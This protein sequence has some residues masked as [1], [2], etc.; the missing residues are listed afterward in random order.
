MTGDPR[1]RFDTFMGVFTPTLLTILG[2]I[3]YVRL[4]WVVGNA[5]LLGAWLILLLALGI[6]AATALSLSSIATNTRIGDGGPY[7]IIARSLGF[8][9]GG[10]VG[11]P[12]F[13]TRPLGIAMYIFGFREGWQWVFPEHPALLIDLTT[14]GVLFG[15]AWLSADL[16]FRVQ[17]AI[18]AVILAS[19]VSIVAS[20]VT[21][22]PLHDIPWWGTYPGSPETGLSGTNFWG[23]FA[24]FFPA[25][26]GILAGANM[27]GELKDPRRAIPLGTLAAIVVASFIY[28]A[29]SVWALQAGTV[30]ELVSNYTLFMDKARWGNLVLAGLLGATAS[31]ALAGLVGGPRILL[32]I[33]RHRLLPAGEW[34]GTVSKDGEPRN[35]M[36]VTGVLTLACLMLRDLNAIA[37]MVTMFFLITYGSLNLVILV[38]MKLGLV[39]FRPTFRIHWSVPLFGLIGSALAMFIVSPLFGVLSILTVALLYLWIERRGVPAGEGNVRSPIFLAIAEWAASQVEGR[40]RYSRRAWKPNLLVPVDDPEV[41]RGEYSFLEDMVRPEGS[42]KLMGLTRGAELQP[43]RDSISALANDFREGGITCSWSVVE[44]DGFGEGVVA[45]L[46]ALQSA[47]FRPNMLF[48]TLPD[49][50]D[51]HEEFATLI[52][53]ARETRVGVALLGLHPTAGL[54]QR[55]RIN[56][57]LRPQGPD[58]DVDSAFQVGS[59]NL[60]MLMGYRL[61]R[62]WGAEVEVMTVVSDEA[63]RAQAEWYL[64]EVCDLVRMPDSVSRR[65]LCGGFE[66]AVRSAPVADLNIL[67]LQRKPDFDFVTRMIEA[68]RGSVLMVLDSGRE[69]ARV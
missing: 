38:E 2:V 1:R 15:V 4:G 39:S 66:D 31:S 25:T 61:L 43:F 42:I 18:M 32:A 45:G 37:P 35:A 33:G 5:G 57:W 9:T 59:L 28:F 7:A 51:R 34:L 63:D 20:P 24:V 68:G 30:D 14:F 8:E 62:R 67:G 36:L 10:A 50:Q 11:V 64:S 65:V 12:L 23:V 27:S 46:Q 26:T 56:L 52:E 58:W 41:I 54:G 55:R 19:L 29:L 60:T 44:E 16:A 22:Q 49:L 6:T 69:S 17:Y 53:Q 40:D 21:L 13:L 48:L 47:F 3:M